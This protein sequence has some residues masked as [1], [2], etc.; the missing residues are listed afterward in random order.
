MARARLAAKPPISMGH[1]R[2]PPDRTS[3]GSGRCTPPGDLRGVTRAARRWASGSV[4]ATL[5]FTVGAA[6]A[7]LAGCATE[8]KKAKRATP[9]DPGAEYY[10]DDPPE[11]EDPLDPI[12]NDDPGAFGAASRPKSPDAAADAGSPDSGAATKAFCSGP[13]KAF[14]LQISELMIASRAGA[15]DGGEWVELKNI[16]ACWLKLRGVTIESPR[17]SSGVDRATVEEDLELGPGESLVVAGSA[18]PAKNHALPG[19]LVAFGTTDV[20]KNSGDTIVVKSGDVVIDTLTYP[21]FSNL[22]AGRSIAF[23]A[24]CNVSVRADWTRWSLSFGTWTGGASGGMK[25]TPNATND[26]VACY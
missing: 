7:P 16:R 1:R 5:L 21:A 10:D 12:S 18:D 25:G 23:P 3:L 13:L 8:S 15:G 4:V 2:T 11:D 19:P 20:L 17:G 26:D 24:D 22:E 6:S 9:V 14:D